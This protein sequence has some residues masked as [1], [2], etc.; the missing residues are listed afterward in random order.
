MASVVDVEVGVGEVGERPT[1]RSL[2]TCACIN[3][4]IELVQVLQ[5]RYRHADSE[6][7]PCRQEIRL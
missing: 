7:L 1:L 6:R 5:T 3:V 4:M 2:A